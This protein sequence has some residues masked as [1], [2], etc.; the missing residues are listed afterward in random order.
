MSESIHQTVL[1]KAP[2][3][4]IYDVLLDE[5]KFGQMTSSPATISSDVG[6]FFTLFGGKV[7]GRNIKLKPGKYIVQA[8]RVSIWDEGIYSTIIFELNNEGRETRLVFRQSGFPVGT[9]E[10]LESGWYK[11]YWEPLREYLTQNSES[12]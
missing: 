9:K 7:T 1:L 3:E 12:K 8:W 2:A 6:G 5:I 10:H 11:M 4:T